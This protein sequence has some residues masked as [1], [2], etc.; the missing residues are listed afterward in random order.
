MS[1]FSLKRLL[2]RDDPVP[3]INGVI[4][5]DK[6]EID[7][8][9]PWS[10]D[11]SVREIRTVVRPK[12]RAG[13]P[14]KDRLPG[15]LLGF[16]GVIIFAALVGAGIVAYE[17]QRL[18]A[19]D[20]NHTGEAITQADELRAIIIAG[21]PDAGWVAMAL[22]ALV[23]ALRG[24]SSLRARVGVLIFFGL[25]LGAQVLYAPKSPE[26]VLVA[27]IAPITMAWM[28]ETFIVE[29][30][31][32]AM[33]RRNIDAL[34]ETPILTGVLLALVRLVRGVLGLIM[35]LIRLLFDARGTWKGV[36]GWVLETAPMAPGRTL[37]G[38]RAAEAL[39][40][41]STLRQRLSRRRPRP[42]SRCARWKRL[43][44]RPGER[45]RGKWRRRR[46][47]RPPRSSGYA[48]RPPSRSGPYSKRQRPPP[49][50]KRRHSPA[51]RRERRSCARHRKMPPG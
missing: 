24:Q 51:P 11:Q 48:A 8:L 22:V 20:H 21:L 49:R 41:A 37:A 26:G 18:F 12:G 25:S 13:A 10:A 45:A 4:H 3:T 34:D 32:W 9:T 17:A 31:R 30:R 40:Q 35:W 39:A 1:K 5:P 16:A 47:P 29:V 6:T 36:R 23:A 19:L 42:P 7:P 50:R 43:P 33:S 28:L 46:Q 38:I 14:K 2:G 44:S 27:V 15:R